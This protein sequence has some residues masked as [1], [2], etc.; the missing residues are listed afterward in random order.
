MWGTKS[1]YLSNESTYLDE[2]ML[3]NLFYP[4]GVN[5]MS[6]YLVRIHILMGGIELNFDLQDFYRPRALKV[7]V[8]QENAITLSAFS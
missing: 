1:I 6:N 2:N 4:N 7:V 8:F 3:K 5:K